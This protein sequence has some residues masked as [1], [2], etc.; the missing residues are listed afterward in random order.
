MAVIKATI[1]NRRIDAPAPDEYLDGTQV[2]LTVGPDDG[3]EPMSPEAA[4]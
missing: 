3:D 4:C 1:R 2:V